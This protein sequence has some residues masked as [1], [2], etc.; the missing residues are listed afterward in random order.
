MP[1]TIL[2]VED[3]ESVRCV[4]QRIIERQG[5]AVLPAS[6]GKAA[7][8]ALESHRFDLVITDIVMPEMD[9]LE[10][11]RALRRMADRPRVIAMSGGRGSATSYLAMALT[12]GAEATLAK[13]VSGNELIDEIE[14]V[15]A[16]G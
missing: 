3:D 16:G 9:G 5:H 4:V 8:Q 15:M 13:P 12:F 10:L 11:V 7:L 14:R 1:Y 6:N 2:L